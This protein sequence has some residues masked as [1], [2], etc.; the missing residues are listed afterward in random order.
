MHTKFRMYIKCS[1]KNNTFVF[2]KEFL[3]DLIQDVRKMQLKENDTFV[4][5]TKL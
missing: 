5:E 3:S 4:L 1:K 2:G